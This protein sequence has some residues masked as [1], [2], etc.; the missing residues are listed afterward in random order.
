MKKFL[1]IHKKILQFIS[2]IVFIFFKLKFLKKVNT[3]KIS[4]KNLVIGYWLAR[5]GAVKNEDGW[6]SW[7]TTY[8]FAS[9]VL[10]GVFFEFYVFVSYIYIWCKRIILFVFS[11]V[12]LV[13][14]VIFSF[15]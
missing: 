2:L 5:F 3:E 7:F 13:L 1:K 11:S 9:E 15:L 8:L 14:S 12:V 4:A 6:K 10:I